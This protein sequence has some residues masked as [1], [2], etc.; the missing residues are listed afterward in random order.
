[1]LN[2]RIELLISVLMASTLMLGCSNKNKVVEENTNEVIHETVEETVEEE[3]IDEFAYE[4]IDEKFERLQSMLEEVFKKHNIEY[5]LVYNGIESYTALG[6]GRLFR[7]VYGKSQDIYNPAI[8]V[9]GYI[10]EDVERIKE[11][12]FKMEESLLGDIAKVLIKDGINYSSVNEQV[13]DGI[14]NGAWCIINNQYGK[15]KEHIGIESPSIAP[16]RLT[17]SYTIEF[18]N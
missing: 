15:I 1:M 3:F 17:F 16:N 7:F 9:L 12:R 6:D 8:S 4:T 18:D 11:N 10:D 14:V 13:T 5:E 2:K